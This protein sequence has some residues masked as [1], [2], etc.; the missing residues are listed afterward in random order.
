MT[1]TT[2]ETTLSRSNGS[3]MKAKSNFGGYDYILLW[4]DYPRIGLD[5]RDQFD[6]YEDLPGGLEG[7]RKLVERFHRRGVKVFIP[8]KPWDAIDKPRGEHFARQA[9]IIRETGADGI[10]LDTMY[11]SDR[12]FRNALDKV[13]SDAVFVSEGRPEFEG[14]KLVTGSWNQSGGQSNHM[15]SVD[16]LRFVFPEHIVYNINR[17]ARKR[18]D[19]IYNSLFNGTGFI[20]WED[21]FGEI[22]PFSWQ[23]R[24]LIR[25][26]NRII[27]ENSNAFLS[28]APVPLVPALHPKLFVNSFQSTVSGFIPAGSKAGNR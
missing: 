7:V 19:L 12:Q 1:S 26:Y 21:I 3:S 14:L 8:Y 18:D 20:V 9:R 10:F 6:F 22:N 25:R 5:K 27:H 4:H 23:E 2:L 13:G 28:P 11:E 24:V 15:P 16:L 17:S